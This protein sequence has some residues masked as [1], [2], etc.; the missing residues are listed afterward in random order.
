[1]SDVQLVSLA[2][3]AVIPTKIHPDFH[4][5]L[6]ATAWLLNTQVVDLADYPI[7]SARIA[8]LGIAH[9]DS[10][11]ACLVATCA[12]SSAVNH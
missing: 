1:M 10:S 12:R 3:C 4:P 2:A 8:T 9:H 5:V 6:Y 7:T 11:V